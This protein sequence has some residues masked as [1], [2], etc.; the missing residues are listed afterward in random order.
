MCSDKDCYYNQAAL[1]FEFNNMILT[2]RDSINLFSADQI[3]MVFQKS[4]WKNVQFSPLLCI[5][6]EVYHICWVS[7]EDY[8]NIFKLLTITYA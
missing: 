5:R 6:A 3:V 1:L 2:L 8:M 7:L 4:V